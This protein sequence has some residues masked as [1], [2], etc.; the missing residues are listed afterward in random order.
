M[1]NFVATGSDARRAFR[2]YPCE[3]D[4]HEPEE[5]PADRKSIRQHALRVRLVMAEAATAG[6]AAKVV[7]SWLTEASWAAAELGLDQPRSEAYRAALAAGTSW[8]EADSG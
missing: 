1:R 4:V 3:C 2:E 6:G 8:R 7:E 5:V